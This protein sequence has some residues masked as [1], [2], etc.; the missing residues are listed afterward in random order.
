MADEG[1]DEL[2]LLL[3]EKIEPI[4]KTNIKIRIVFMK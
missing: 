4:P 2:P 1:V 3:H